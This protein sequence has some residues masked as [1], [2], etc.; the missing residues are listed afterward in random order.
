[1]TVTPYDLPTNIDTISP[2]TNPSHSDLH[3][4]ANGATLDLDRRVAN[5]ESVVRGLTAPSGTIEQARLAAHTVMVRGPVGQELN[6]TLLVPVLWNMTGRPVTYQAA[7]ATLLI[8][9]DADFEVD[10]VNGL[11]VEGNTFDADLHTSILKEGKRLVIPAG[12]FTSE[13]L[14]VDDFDGSQAQHTYLAV[15]VKSMGSVDA[16]GGS[17]TVQLNRN[18]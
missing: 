13:E 12:E 7:K 5:V 3:N 8:A 15:V 2:L 9:A 1:V 6:G 18:L 14:H 10:I 4:L 11:D 17:L 16:P